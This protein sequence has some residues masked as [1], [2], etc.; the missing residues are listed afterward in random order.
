MTKWS[1]CISKERERRAIA[2]LLGLHRDT[3]RRYINA[4]CFPEIVRPGKRSKLDPYKASLRERWTA[5]QHN[6][7][8]LVSELRERGYRQGETIVNDHVA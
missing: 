2:E 6:I 8:Q 4:A 5:G 1:L 3:V 7:K